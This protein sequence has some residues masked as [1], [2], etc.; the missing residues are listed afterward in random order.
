MAYGEADF[1]GQGV[2]AFRASFIAVAGMGSRDSLIA[3]VIT[4]D[5]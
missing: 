1:S 5:I 4:G 3:S 2:L